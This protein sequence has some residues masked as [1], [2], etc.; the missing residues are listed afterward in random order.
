MVY[1]E[2]SIFDK[3]NYFFLWAKNYKKK[4]VFNLPMTLK[5]NNIAES[6]NY[7]KGKW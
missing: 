3:W 7:E 6:E 4:N 5:E 2:Y 1:I